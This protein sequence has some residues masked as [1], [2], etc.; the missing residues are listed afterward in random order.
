MRDPTGAGDSFAGGF[1]GYLDGH[2]EAPDHA[3]LRRAMAYG[4]VMASYNVERFGTE[5]VASL[6]REEIEERFREL[7][8]ITQFEER[9]IELRA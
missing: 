3:G 6:T 8:A 4:T 7:L 9:P 5:R 1:I 2:D